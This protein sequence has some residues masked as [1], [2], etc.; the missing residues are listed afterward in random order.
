MREMKHAY[1]THIFET[2]LS[3]S[4]KASSYLRALEMLGEI[5]TVSGGT[6][7]NI[8]SIW[9]CTSPHEIDKLYSYI[10]E[11]QRTGKIF[12]TG[13]APSYWKNGYY[14]AA[15]RT[16]RDFLIEHNHANK[17]SSLYSDDAFN[18]SGE[19]LALSDETLLIRDLDSYEGQEVVRETKHRV[20][21][22][23]F[24]RK[25]LEIYGSSCCITGLSIPG[26]NVASHIIPWQNRP[27]IRLDPRNG[28]CLSSTYDAA[29]DRHLVGLDENYRVILSDGIKEHFGNEVNRDYFETVEG[30][31]ITLPIKFL[32]SQE[33]L[34]EHRSK[35]E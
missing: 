2:N 16:Y 14:S 26:V 35:L 8:P 4:K 23:V 10:K 17:L 20:N 25:I 30:Q 31:T 9:K 18:A 15:L 22:Q 27:D 29:F 32:P 28:L 7:Q 3:G 6:F 21:Q 5:L 12:D 34:A 33:W 1:R 13:H 24:R 19:D 11:A